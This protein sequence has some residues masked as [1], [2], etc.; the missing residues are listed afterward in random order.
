VT[1]EQQLAA[2]TTLAGDLSTLTSEAQ[3]AA[4]A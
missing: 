4:R 3:M 1:P 2:I